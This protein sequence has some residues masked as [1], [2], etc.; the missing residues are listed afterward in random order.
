MANDIILI[1]ECAGVEDDC[2]VP[3]SMIEGHRTVTLQLKNVGLGGP[4]YQFDHDDS[5]FADVAAVVFLADS[6]TNQ[7]FLVVQRLYSGFGLALSPM[8][9]AYVSV[10][11]QGTTT[12]Y[13][14]TVPSSDEP[15]FNWELEA[16]QPGIP[17]KI[18]VKRK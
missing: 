5:S 12:T 14:F 2:E 4:E 16:T 9:S 10:S 8:S 11:S 6:S 17:L 3:T 13:T 18:T 1:G 7:V 15:N